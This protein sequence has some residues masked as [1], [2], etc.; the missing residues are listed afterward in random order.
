MTR[1]PLAA[2]LLIAL[3]AAGSAQYAPAPVMP[4]PER[5]ELRQD[6]RQ[7]TD[8][9]RDLAWF[10]E[11]VSRYDAARARRSRRALAAVEHDVAWALE[12]ELREARREVGQARREARSD[13]REDRHERRDDR[14]DLRDDR[15]DARQIEALRAEFSDLRGRMSPRALDRKRMVIVELTHVA[16]AEL[17]EDRRELREDR[18]EAHA[19]GY[20]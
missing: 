19:D 10:E 6:R 7:L 8:D 1:I 18:R 9:R 14:R 2:A 11:L 13:W 17:R 15:R 4:V 12:R 3:P 20:R 5:H 16:R